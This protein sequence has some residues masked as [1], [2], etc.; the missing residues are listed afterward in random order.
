MENKKLEFI[1]SEDLLNGILAYLGKQ[2]FEEVFQ[3]IEGIQKTIRPFEPEK[4]EKEQ[5]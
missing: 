1:V 4:K 3:L 5:E 2:P